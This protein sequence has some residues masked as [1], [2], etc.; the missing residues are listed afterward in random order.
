M[1]AK[2]IHAKTA[3]ASIT[4][5]L[6]SAIAILDG[7]EVFAIVRQMSVVTGPAKMEVNVRSWHLDI[8]AAVSLAQMER[9]ASIM[10][11][12]ASPILACMEIALMG[13][14]STLVTAMLASPARFVTSKLMNARAHLV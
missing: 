2:T 12:S 11:M 7:P 1:T 14:I 6:L 8:G 4:L 13:S 5:I 9:T 3:D 10:S